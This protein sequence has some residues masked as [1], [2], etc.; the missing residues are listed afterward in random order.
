MCA[1]ADA[2]RWVEEIMKELIAAGL[3]ESDL[4]SLV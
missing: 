4:S 3:N 2:V 1:I